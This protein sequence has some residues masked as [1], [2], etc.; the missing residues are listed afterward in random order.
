[1]LQEGRNNM[2]KKAN[3]RISELLGIDPIPEPIEQIQE[4]KG[5]VVVVEQSNTNVVVTDPNKSIEES[6]VD[7]DFAEARE[8]LKTIIEKSDEAITDLQIVARETESPRAYE[9]LATL[10]KQAQEANK[11][12]LELSKRRQELKRPIEKVRTPATVEK[13]QNG[14][15]NIEKAIFVGTTADLDKMI[16]EANNQLAKNEI[17]IPAEI[18]DRRENE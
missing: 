3:E 13:N 11:D 5:E 14:G 10:L 9:V 16:E 15:V 1:M 8:N 2:H 17:I 18:E 4:T 7:Q 6:I 12:L